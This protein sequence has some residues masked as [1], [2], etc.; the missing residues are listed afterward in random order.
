MATQ[1]HLCQLPILQEKRDLVTRLVQPNDVQ[2]VVFPQCRPGSHQKTHFRLPNK[3]RGSL[4]A[5]CTV[6]RARE[7]CA[8]ARV[9]VSVVS[10]P[11][12]AFMTVATVWTR[13]CQNQQLLYKKLVQVQT[14]SQNSQV[15]NL[16]DH[17]SS[18]HRQCHFCQL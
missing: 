12:V 2:R 9:Q 17:L 16:S 7:K 1:S 3:L 10:A 4:S 11:S 14:W 8:S 18:C 15:S 13:N 6:M 5:L